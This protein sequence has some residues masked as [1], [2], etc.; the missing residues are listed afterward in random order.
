MPTL[1]YTDSAGALHEPLVLP[2]PAL[3]TAASS[4]LA[5]R[6]ARS[7]ARATTVARAAPRM[8]SGIM[9]LGQR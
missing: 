4:E 3:S 6:M 2:V 5:R 7:M 8:P 1:R 9:R